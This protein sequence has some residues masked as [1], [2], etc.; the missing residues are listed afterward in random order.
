MEI[1]PVLL[2]HLGREMREAVRSEVE[3]WEGRG[4]L[5]GTCS[6]AGPYL[7]GT[8][9]QPLSFVSQSLTPTFPG[10]HRLL[11]GPTPPIASHCPVFDQLIFSA[12]NL[13]PLLFYSVSLA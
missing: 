11:T 7:P 2:H 4:L 10:S 12:W 8:F 3:F 9:L 5:S 6:Q 13:F 1:S